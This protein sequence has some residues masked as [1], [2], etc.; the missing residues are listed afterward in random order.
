VRGQDGDLARAVALDAAR[1]L[2]AQRTGLLL[3]LPQRG[4][5]LFS[6]MAHGS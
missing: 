5:H 6:V 4:Q 2:L 1:Q 3:D